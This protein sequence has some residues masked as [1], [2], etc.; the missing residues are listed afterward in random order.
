MIASAQHCSG[1]GLSYDDVDLFGRLRSL[2][3]VR[4]LPLPDTVRAVTG[5]N[6]ERMGV[7][8]ATTGSTRRSLVGELGRHVRDVERGAAVARAV[9]RADHREQ[10]R[11]SAAGNGSAVT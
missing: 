9:G 11:V 6:A 8:G 10:G 3:I 2:T 4:G 7:C 5:R 1:G